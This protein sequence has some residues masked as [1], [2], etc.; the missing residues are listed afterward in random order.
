MAS[1]FAR[2]LEQTETQYKVERQVQA[3]V[4]VPKKRWITKGEKFTYSLITIVAI[5]VS[6]YVVSFSSSI[7]SV[8]RDIESLENKVEEQLLAN[9]T[10]EAQVNE[11]SEPSRII[12]VAKANGLDIKNATV[13]QAEILQN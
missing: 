4:A 6:I 3:P 1:V 8:N 7:D 10:L 11:L 2:K 12:E 5:L 9:E 13:E